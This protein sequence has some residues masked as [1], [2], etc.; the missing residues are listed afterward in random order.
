MLET[1]VASQPDHPGL[2]HYI[3]HAYDV[4]PLADGRSQAARRYA[5]IAPS[6]PHALHMPSHTFTRVGYWQESI[7]TNIASRPRPRSARARPAKRCTRW[8]IWPTRTCRPAQDGAATA[9]N[10]APS[11]RAG[12][13]PTPGTHF[14]M[15]YRTLPLVPEFPTFGPRLSSANGAGYR[16]RRPTLIQR[17]GM[18]T[19]VTS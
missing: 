14:R 1:L 9:T 6:A 12:D 7:D 3:I 8:T 11:R 13:F 4:P 18:S 15:A 19:P 16:S 10:T 17:P 5:T 2:A